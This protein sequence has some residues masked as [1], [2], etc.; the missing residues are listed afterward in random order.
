MQGVNISDKEELP[1]IENKPLFW[2][3]YGIYCMIPISIYAWYLW[4]RSREVLSSA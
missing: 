1:T 4:K 3:I 2:T